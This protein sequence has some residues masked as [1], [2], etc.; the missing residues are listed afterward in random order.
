MAD[1]ILGTNS[2]AISSV[3]PR[4]I[5]AAASTG[6]AHFVKRLIL[7]NAHATQGTT[8]TV[9]TITGALTLAV[10]QLGALETYPLPF[11]RELELAAADGIEGLAAGSAGTVY[12]TAHGKTSAATPTT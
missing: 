10:V 1:N 5:V 12:V 2:T 9:R 6:K 3:T 11:D 4:T 7:T 8:I